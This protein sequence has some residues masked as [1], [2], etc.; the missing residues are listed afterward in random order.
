MQVPERMACVEISE[1]G[2][3]SGPGFCPAEAVKETSMPAD[4]AQGATVASAQR[5]F[6][7]PIRFDR[8]RRRN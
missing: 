6:C 3:P 4:S 8:R 7:Q 2:G 1:P 5:S